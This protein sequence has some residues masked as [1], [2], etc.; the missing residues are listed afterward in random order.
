LVEFL[1]GWVK[2]AYEP[3][4]FEG[5]SE[6]LMLV[7]VSEGGSRLVMAFLIQ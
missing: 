3:M 7:R 4:R 1:V 5:R 2:R 6:S